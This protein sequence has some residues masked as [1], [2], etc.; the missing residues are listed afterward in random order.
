[1][2]TLISF[3]QLVDLPV[4]HTEFRPKSKF[5]PYNSKGHFIN[6]F[7]QLVLADL[8]NLCQKSSIK[9]HSNLSLQEKNALQILK[10]N[11]NLVIKSADKGGGIVI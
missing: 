2:E 1:M 4:Q 10:T 7:Q 8:K 5:Y 9:G 6:T 11:K 3:L